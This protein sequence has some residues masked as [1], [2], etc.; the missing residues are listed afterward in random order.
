MD[1]GA[2]IYATYT[3]YTDQRAVQINVQ[4]QILSLIESVAPPRLSK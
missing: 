3:G 1:P 4:V 2:G